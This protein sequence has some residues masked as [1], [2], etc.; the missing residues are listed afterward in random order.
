MRVGLLDIAA[1]GAL[2]GALLLPAPSREIQ[3]LFSSD[4]SLAPAIA[5]AQAEAQRS[6]PD[7]RAVARLADLL[8]RARQTDW[9][10][11][12]AIAGAAVPSPGQ[13][14]PMVAA[15]TTAAERA[16]LL[17]AYAWAARALA[18]CEEPHSDCAELERGRLEIYV[19][20]LA[21]VVESGIDPV[22]NPKGFEDVV[23]KAVPLIR[24]GKPK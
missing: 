4:T 1:A 7:G 17:T 21:A 14:R 2:A 9:A 12:V 15:S 3:P 19:K 13:W 6:P 24:M 20:A 5:K 16:D 8:V 23:R 10:M 22:K 18:V 11:R